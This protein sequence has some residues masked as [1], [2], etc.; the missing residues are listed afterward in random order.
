MDTMGKFQK[1]LQ[2]E[3]TAEEI[4]NADLYERID[5]HKRVCLNKAKENIAFEQ[6]EAQRMEG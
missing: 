5:Y 3:L 2:I 4:V 6:A 1:L